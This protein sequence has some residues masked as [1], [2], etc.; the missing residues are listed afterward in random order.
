[1]SPRISQLGHVKINYKTTKLVEHGDP[2]PAHGRGRPDRNL[3]TFSSARY[4]LVR[5]FAW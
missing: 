5:E 4:A 2:T 1:M 3:S